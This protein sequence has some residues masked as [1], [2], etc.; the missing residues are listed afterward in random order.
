MKDSEDVYD[1]ARITFSVAGN[2]VINKLS[3]SSLAFSLDMKDKSSADFVITCESADIN[4]ANSSSLKISEQSKNSVYSIQGSSKTDADIETN[5][6]KLSSKGNSA[7]TLSGMAQTAIF[8]MTGT[9][10]VDLIT[11]F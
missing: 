9:S 6:F 1:K 4:M 7:M 8:D 11:S 5:E 10:E 2:A 3:V